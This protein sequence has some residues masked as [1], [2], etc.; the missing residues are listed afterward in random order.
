VPKTNIAAEVNSGGEGKGCLKQGG[1]APLI[2]RKALENVGKASLQVKLR[3][4]TILAASR[5]K[6]DSNDDKE[7]AAMEDKGTIIKVVQKEN[8]APAAAGDFSSSRRPKMPE[9]RMPPAMPLPEETPLPETPV[10]QLEKSGAA[11]APDDDLDDSLFE[12]MDT[13]SIKTPSAS[14]PK[15]GLRPHKSASANKSEISTSKPV[16]NSTAT[17][18]LFSSVSSHSDMSLCSPL[19]D[20]VPEDEELLWLEER[21]SSLAEGTRA[22]LVSNLAGLLKRSAQIPASP[23]VQDPGLIATHPDASPSLKNLP[24]KV[25]ATSQKKLPANLKISQSSPNIPGS[26]LRRGELKAATGSSGKKRVVKSVAA[27][28]SPLAK[29]SN[30]TRKAQQT[31]ML[32]SPEGKRMVSSTSPLVSAC[33]A[34]GRMTGSPLVQAVLVPRRGKVASV[35]PHQGVPFNVKP[36]SSPANLS[37]GRMAREP[38]SSQSPL[39]LKS[40][41]APTTPRRHRLLPLKPLLNVLDVTVDPASTATLDSPLKPVQYTEVH[42]IGKRTLPVYS[43][44]PSSPNSSASSALAP[45]KTGLLGKS[46][47]SS[48]LPL[49]VSTVAKKS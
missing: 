19:P 18:S 48:R 3:K 36:T 22:E 40:S 49:P 42:R 26:D 7:E 47:S 5:L 16:N 30:F 46:S 1:R 24:E 34:K 41:S 20:L 45:S 11:A 23:L 27:T 35:R 33:P 25:I 32:P 10:R 44:S 13:F 31:S 4:G 21:R 39:P 29:D 15:S 28:P 37:G 14:C 9:A 6:K 12:A 43:N 8:L 2:A 38:L 17:S